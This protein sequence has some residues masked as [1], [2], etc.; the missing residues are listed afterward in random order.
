MASIRPVGFSRDRNRRRRP[1][2]Y[3]PEAAALERREL[4][5]TFVVQNLNDRGTDALRANIV[6]VQNGDTIKFAKGLTGSITLTSGSLVVSSGLDVDGSGAG[7]LTIGGDEASRVFFVKNPSGKPVSSPTAVSA[8][9]V[10]F[11]GN[12]AHDPG[13]YNMVATE[14]QNSVTARVNQ[15]GRIASLGTMTLKGPEIS[16]KAASF[17]GDH[18]QTVRPELPRQ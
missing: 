7:K 16:G 5:N 10:R 15:G 14:T 3:Q 9:S 17:F 12:E 6:Q 4:L 11:S 2:R 8:S 18:G 13:P 1:C